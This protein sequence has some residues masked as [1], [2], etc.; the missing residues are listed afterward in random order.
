MY[1]DTA[2]ITAQTNYKLLTGSV[3]PRPIAWVST[4][5]AD[6]V[7][8]LAPYSFF[9]VASVNPPV[10]CVVQVTP[11]DRAQ[12]DT[13][14]NLAAGG[15]CVVNI[16]SHKLAEQMNASCG[17]Y[18]PE[19]SEFDKAGL[20]KSVSNK[21]NAPGVQDAIVRFECTVREL[22]TIA[23]NPMG[24]SMMLLDVQGVE[25]ADLALDGDK[26]RPD[27]LD[28]IGKTGGDGYTTT[29]DRFEMARPSV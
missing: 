16:V 5:S 1:F 13:L 8:N 2:S 21:V 6:G 14:R 7:A 10:L 9:T 24:G 19:V 20:A 17:D 27:L 26:V 23:D 28:A 22:K 3:T 4:L 25:V 18:P 15:D 29:R 11:R 12:K